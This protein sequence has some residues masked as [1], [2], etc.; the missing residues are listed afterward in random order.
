MSYGF[1]N[2]LQRAAVTFYKAV[3]A[4][5]STLPHGSTFKTQRIE[6]QII[7]EHQMTERLQ[8]IYIHVT[9]KNGEIVSAN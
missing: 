3:L 4:P 2:T 9:E 5:F 8:S 6:F 7:D 1:V